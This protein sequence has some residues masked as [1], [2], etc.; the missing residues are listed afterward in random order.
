MGAYEVKTV[1][2]TRESVKSMGGVTILP[3]VAIDDVSV[4]DIDLLILP[5]GDSWTKPEQ[6]GVLELAKQMLEAN[7]LVT[8][9][10]AS[11]VGLARTGL[12][13]QVE[14][15]SNDLS[16]LKAL[17]PDYTGENHYRNQPTVTTDNLIT[18]N[19]TASVQFTKAVLEK[20]GVMTDDVLQAWYDLY[21][22]QNLD[23]Y[24]RLQTARKADKS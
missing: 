19:G 21:T 8:A 22:T 17:A 11:T 18:A 15:T 14:H 2:A 7:K 12:L 1:G 5:G 13:D 20:L 23:A 6:E 3:D 4:D 10:C 16:L 9:I 24:F